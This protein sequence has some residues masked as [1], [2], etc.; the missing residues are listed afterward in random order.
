MNPRPLKPC[1]ELLAQY[2]KPQRGRVVVLAVLILGTIAD[3]T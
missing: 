1:W 3:Y 2:L